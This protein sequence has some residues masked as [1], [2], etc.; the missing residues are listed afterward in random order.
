MVDYRNRFIDG[1]QNGRG[2]L[3][4][5]DRGYERYMVDLYPDELAVVD[6]LVHVTWIFGAL[7]FAFR[8]SG[9]EGCF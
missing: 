8:T 5:T 9:V 7:F 4:L 2:N 1:Y 3:A 6:I